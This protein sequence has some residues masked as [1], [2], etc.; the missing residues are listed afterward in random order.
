MVSFSVS[1]Q[2]LPASAFGYNL[3]AKRPVLLTLFVNGR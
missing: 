3:K 2:M 1:R